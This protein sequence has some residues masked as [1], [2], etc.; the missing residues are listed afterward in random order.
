[1]NRSELEKIVKFFEGEI[2]KDGIVNIPFKY[3][4]RYDFWVLG[5]EDCYFDSSWN[6]LNSLIRKIVCDSKKY[7]LNRCIDILNSI[8]IYDKIQ[9]VY[10]KVLKCIDIILKYKKSV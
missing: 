1:M 3:Q 9:T 2:H 4:A 6:Q 10:K 7:N 8:K 5:I